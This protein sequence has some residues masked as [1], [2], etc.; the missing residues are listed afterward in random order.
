[1][2]EHIRDHFKG[3]V[4]TVQEA[5][6]DL[7]V[8]RYFTHFYDDAANR[9]RTGEETVDRTFNSGEKEIRPMEGSSKFQQFH[10]PCGD[11]PGHLK[12]RE[13]PCCCPGACNDG[14]FWDCKYTAFA[15]EFFDYFVQPVDTEGLEAS[16]RQKLADKS[17]EAF[18]WD[19]KEGDIV[20]CVSCS[21]YVLFRVVIK[22]GGSST[23]QTASSSFV[24]GCIGNKNKSSVD[25]S[26]SCTG[27]MKAT[28]SS[29]RRKSPAALASGTSA[30][31]KA[32]A[33]DFSAIRGMSG[34]EEPQKVVFV[35]HL[36]ELVHTSHYSTKGRRTVQE[37]DA[38]I[39][40]YKL[41]AN[42]DYT[43]TEYKYSILDDVKRRLWHS[44][45]FAKWA[46]GR[47]HERPAWM[48]G[49][50]NLELE[51]QEG[52]G[53]NVIDQLEKDEEREKQDHEAHDDEGGGIE[54]ED[55]STS[56][57]SRYSS[58]SSGAEQ[59]GG[60]D[61]GERSTSASG[62]NCKCGPLAKS[63]GGRKRSRKRSSDHGM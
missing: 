24:R 46:T 25:N 21:Q 34:G 50:T 56:P 13:Q 52:I 44:F 43:H 17:Q 4:A 39:L 62:R 42:R 36:E 55:G 16:R 37:F 35:K 19:L 1:V 63:G 23:S 3:K 14:R 59:K 58:N 61:G 12:V 31:G 7:Q 30:K 2:Y 27:D 32:N 8:N 11:C 15:G 54:V 5:P 47:T 10:G 49:E 41:V 53:S 38:S 33:S 45:A 48:A 22:R 40:P 20:A 57:K 28:R 26:T 18:V 29:S 6:G 9:D 60:N 51:Q